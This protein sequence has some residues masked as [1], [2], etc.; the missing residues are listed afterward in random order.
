MYVQH[1]CQQRNFLRTAFT[2][3]IINSN[4]NNTFRRSFRALCCFK[5][6]SICSI[7]YLA[8]FSLWDV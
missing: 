1:K 2:I 5:I 6:T 4:W 8:R 7:M 3:N